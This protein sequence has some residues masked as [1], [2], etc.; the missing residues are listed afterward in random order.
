M[1]EEAELEES[2]P[3]GFSF[4]IRLP[5]GLS[6]PSPPSGEIMMVS[7]SVRSLYPFPPPPPPRSNSEPTCWPA[8]LSSPAS[9]LGLSTPSPLSSPASRLVKVTH[10]KKIHPIV[11]AG[12]DYGGAVLRTVPLPPPPRK[13]LV[14]ACWPA[15]LS[16]PASR[17]G[18][19]VQ[20]LSPPPPRKNL[21]SACWPALL[22]MPAS[23]S[24]CPVQ[25]LLLFACSAE[26]LLADL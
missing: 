5:G 21:V 26:S 12:R 3:A 10:K 18:C 11:V 24:E 4:L 22:S 9:R 1:L 25:S 14:S 20:S 23:R 7:S 15:L 17:S 16:M 8:P 19:S 2:T 6:T 13:N